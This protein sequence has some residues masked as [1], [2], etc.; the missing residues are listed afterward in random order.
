MD[1]PKISIIPKPL[2]IQA[3]SGRLTFDSATVVNASNGHPELGPEGYT[4]VID[5]DGI[6]F[7]TGT[8]TGQ[9]YAEQTLKQLLPPDALRSDAG[10][11]AWPLPY[12]TITDAP[13][14]RWRGAMLDVARHFLPKRDVLRFLDLMAL[15]KLNVLHFHL[16]ED[17]GW[18]IEIKQYPKLTEVG[19]W[20]RETVGDG[21]PHGGFYTQDDIREIVAYATERHITVVPEIDI[22][23][24]ST[25]A[26]AAYPELGN[27]DV[28]SA[29]EPRE[30]WTRFGIA[31]SVLN[32]ED[33]TVEFYKTVMDEICDLFPG[34][35]VCLG[36]DECPKDEWKA[37][38][39]AQARK[40]ELGL[41]TEEDLQ[42]WF[43]NQLS[44]HVASKGRK[45]L[46][47]DEI[48]EGELFPGTVVSSWRGTD[49]AVEAARR[50][51][52]TLTSPY[53]W[54]YFD[55]RQSDEEGEPGAPWAAPTSLERAY[56]F[57]PIPEDMPEE[58]ADHVIGSEA[59]LWSEYIPDARVHDYQAWPRLAAFSETVWSTPDR[60]FAEF[61]SRLEKHLERL[62][63]LGVEYRPLD[64][65]HPW[66]KQPAPHWKA[67]PNE[68]EAADG[69][70]STEST[71]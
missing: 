41:A 64:G 23:G 7:V 3:G 35:F 33:T 71:E 21:R 50:G 60:D 53:G 17:Q 63:A 6:T 20:R 54:V 57:E 37:S 34:E 4:L 15:H 11:K 49:G 65:P 18:R 25:A 58:L 12:V 47:W 26:I 42:A 10:D 69:T 56:S 70:E 48:L 68:A 9:F 55:Y 44:E 52:D 59:T 1:A 5:D 30:V 29:E 45:L 43:M 28:P 16:T 67:D 66:Q 36:G 24:H 46:G 19:G 40:A 22:P 31:T 13:R 38:A 62:D 51:H 61:Q 27:Q 8:E 14:F 39:R 2:R 32:V